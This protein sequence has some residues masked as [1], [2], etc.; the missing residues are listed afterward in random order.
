MCTQML[1]KVLVALTLVLMITQQFGLCVQLL[2]RRIDVLHCLIAKFMLL[3]MAQTFASK[4][5]LHS[6]LHGVLKSLMALD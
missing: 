4:S 1:L 2:Q 3:L 5:P 6:L